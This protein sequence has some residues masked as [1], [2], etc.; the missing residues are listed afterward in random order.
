[1]QM[2]GEWR[3]ASS[4]LT[5]A[6]HGGDWP[7]TLFGLFTPTRIGY[8]AG[9]APELVRTLW[10]REESLTTAENLTPPVQDVALRY[11]SS[12][13]RRI[14][15]RTFCNHE[16]Y[17]CYR[18]VPGYHRNVISSTNRLREHTLCNTSRTIEQ[19]F[20][21]SY[22]VYYVSTDYYL[23]INHGQISGTI[24]AFTW[25]NWR[26]LKSSVRIVCGPG[27]DASRTP[28]E[29]KSTNLAP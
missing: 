26:K 2:Y 25:Q 14:I 5:S 9:W 24:L 6:I 27:R 11:T 13:L 7:A 18:A 21:L 19:Y 17:N 16:V 1:M 10:K 15:L 3:L 8:E 4:F 22:R 29:Y 20:V 12:G 23:N 28:L